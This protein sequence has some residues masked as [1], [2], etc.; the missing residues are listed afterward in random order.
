MKLQQKGISHQALV[1]L[2][3]IIYSRYNPVIYRAFK[4]LLNITGKKTGFLHDEDTASM[5]KTTDSLCNILNEEDTD[6][7]VMLD[8]IF[9][10]DKDNMSY[11]RMAVPD[12]EKFTDA[13]FVLH[14][15]SVFLKLDLSATGLLEVFVRSDKDS[16][17][18]NFF[19]EKEDVLKFLEG[20]KDILKKMLEQAHVKKSTIGYY[21]SKK[22]VEK[23]NLWCVNF[24]T[25]S[26]FNIKV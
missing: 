26:G 24:Y 9:D 22:V 19:T 5:K 8:L 21:N 13:E 7:S 3:Y 23:I 20:S 2:A 1:D 17:L 11:G 25:K 15:E 16:V 12:G 10:D 6:F 14:N 4:Y 18:I